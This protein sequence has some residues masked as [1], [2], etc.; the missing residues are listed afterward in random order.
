MT[1]LLMR[2]SPIHRTSP[3]QCVAV[4]NQR[5]PVFGRCPVRCPDWIGV[6]VPGVYPV[7]RSCPN[8]L[9]GVVS[10][11][12]GTWTAPWDHFKSRTHSTRRTI[13]AG[14]QDTSVLLSRIT[15]GLDTGEEV[16]WDEKPRGK[17][18]WC[19]YWACAVIVWK[20]FESKNAAMWIV[21]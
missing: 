21:K 10:N 7:L 6:R 14:P 11:S 20:E 9:G 13:P 3:V 2:A 19:G 8:R 1:R 18:C 5:Y 17:L 16:W 15:I 12:G 4:A